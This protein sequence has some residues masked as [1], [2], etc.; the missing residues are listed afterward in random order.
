[1][2]TLFTHSGKWLDHPDGDGWWWHWEIHDVEL[3]EPD[4]CIVQIKGDNVYYGGFAGGGD[5]V[6][7]QGTYGTKTK[8]Q[9]VLPHSP[10]GLNV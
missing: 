9:R 4:I 3:D 8:W 7:L 10:I 1:M 2:S 5:K 6:S